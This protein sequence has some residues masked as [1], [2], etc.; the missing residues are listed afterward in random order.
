MIGDARTYDYTG[1]FIDVSKFCRKNNKTGFSVRKRQTSW[2]FLLIFCKPVIPKSSI[3]TRYTKIFENI[4][5]FFYRFFAQKFAVFGEKT[6]DSPYFGKFPIFC[7]HDFSPINLLWTIC[8]FMIFY[9]SMSSQQQCRVYSR[10][11][12]LHQI[13]FRKL[14]FLLRNAID[15]ISWVTNFGDY[16]YLNFYSTIY[17]CVFYI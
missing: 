9:I 7:H 3:F 1:R 8:H 16:I 13:T 5:E 2:A 17:I 11:I 14:Y 15:T 4:F 12:E 10:K 6:L